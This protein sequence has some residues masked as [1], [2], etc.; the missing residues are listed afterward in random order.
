MEKLKSPDVGGRV[1]KGHRS[2]HFLCNIYLLCFLTSGYQVLLLFTRVQ[3]QPAGVPRLGPPLATA[4][5]VKS[6]LG[7]PAQKVHDALATRRTCLQAQPGGG[8]PRVGRGKG[9]RDRVQ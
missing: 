3:A 6:S 1:M 9:V 7:H 2:Q 4:P 5:D 8:A